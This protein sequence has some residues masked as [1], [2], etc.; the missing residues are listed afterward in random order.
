MKNLGDVDVSKMAQFQHEYFKMVGLLK[1][2]TNLE[3]VVFIGR[4]GL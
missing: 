2:V 4:R 3:R 1:T